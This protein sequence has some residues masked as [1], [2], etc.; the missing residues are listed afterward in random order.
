M[1]FG[2]IATQSLA[3]VMRDREN[4]FPGCGGI[5]AKSLLQIMSYFGPT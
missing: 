5:A 1:P 4:V 2:G 3:Q